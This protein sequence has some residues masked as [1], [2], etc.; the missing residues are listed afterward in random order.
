[1]K[2]YTTKLYLDYSTANELDVSMGRANFVLF[3][4][5]YLVITI[6]K[7][8]YDFILNIQGKKGK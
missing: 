5:K 3:L 4:E 8:C 2:E 7:K 6:D 1:M